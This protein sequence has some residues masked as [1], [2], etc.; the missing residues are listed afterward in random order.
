MSSRRPVRRTSHRRHQKNPYMPEGEPPDLSCVGGIIALAIGLGSLGMI[1]GGCLFYESGGKWVAAAGT[2]IF[3]LFLVFMGI[4]LLLRAPW[5]LAEEAQAW[6]EFGEDLE[7]LT[8]NDDDP[9][10]IR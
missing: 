1:V 5:D 3:I 6:K 8:K 4:M 10:N 9:L 7:A 2:I